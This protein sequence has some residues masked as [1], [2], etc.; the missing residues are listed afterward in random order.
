MK[1]IENFIT[2]IKNNESLQ[3]QL[4]EAVKNNALAAFLKQQGCEA[5]AEAFIGAIKNQAETLDDEALDSVSGGANAD[6]AVLSVLSLGIWCA[7]M[8]IESAEGSGV[9]NGSDGAIL[10]NDL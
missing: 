5:T 10:C 3:M 2:E 9:G 8:A 7:L 1:T 4:A 6:E